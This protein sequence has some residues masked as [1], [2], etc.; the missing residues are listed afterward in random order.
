MPAE[1]G[2]QPSPLVLLAAFAARTK[3]LKL[4]AGVALAPL[5]HTVR[6]AED[7]A[8]LDILSNRRPH[9]HPGAVLC[10]RA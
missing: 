10:G 4:G 9:S 8:V 5:Y 7:C 1:D 3:R 6:F 2:Y